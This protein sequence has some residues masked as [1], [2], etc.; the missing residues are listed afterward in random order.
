M[1]RSGN[2]TG[3]PVLAVKRSTQVSSRPTAL[4][5]RTKTANEVAH[6]MVQE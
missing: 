4:A 6:L 5:H 1:C 2:A 3:T